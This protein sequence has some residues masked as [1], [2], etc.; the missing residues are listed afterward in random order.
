M[1][2]LLILI[3]LSCPIFLGAYRTPAY[4]KNKMGHPI[5]FPIWRIK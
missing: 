4:F 3:G 5:N 2:K 1:N